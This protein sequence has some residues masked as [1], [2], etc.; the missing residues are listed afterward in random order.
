MAAPIKITEQALLDA[1][2]GCPVTSVQVTCSLE[3]LKKREKERGNRF[4][5]SAE[6]SFRYLYPKEGYDL[7]IN[8]EESTPKA[9]AET[10][11]NYLLGNFQA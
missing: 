8:S 3:T 2:E 7:Q 9:S 10:I 6:A 11:R 4:P 1:A 5:G